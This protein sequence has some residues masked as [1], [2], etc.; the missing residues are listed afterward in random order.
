MI[1]LLFC[2]KYLVTRSTVKKNHYKF[3][4]RSSNTS[5][6][7][8]DAFFGDVIKNITR[9]NNVLEELIHNYQKLKHKYKNQ[10][11]FENDGPEPDTSD[12]EI[13]E[14]YIQRNF[15]TKG[16]SNLVVTRSPHG[17]TEMFFDEKEDADTVTE[18]DDNKK[19]GNKFLIISFLI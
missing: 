7:G 4:I 10:D 16:I 12:T 3:Q 19:D 18:D 14:K 8:R 9:V 11:T 6:K 17:K 2:L 13:D 5:E 1:F 15:R